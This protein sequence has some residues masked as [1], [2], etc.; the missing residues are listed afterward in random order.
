M[1][2]LHGSIQ[3]KGTDRWRVFATIRDDEGHPHKLTATV[4]GT[5]ADAELELERLL[6]TDGMKRDR[7]FSELAELYLADAERRVSNGTLAESTLAGYRSKLTKSILPALGRVMVSDITPARVTRFIASLNKDAPGTFRVLRTVLNWAYRNGYMRDRVCDR[8]EPVRQRTGAVTI[9]DVYTSDEVAVILNHPMD[10]ELKTAV[11]IALSCGL[12]RGE[13]CALEW[14]DYD[15]ETIHVRRSWGKDA[16]KTPNS[17]ARL[18]VPKWARDWLD[19]LRDDGLIIGL[20]PNQV[21]EAWRRLWF[22]WSH[23]ARDEA[24][25]V[26]YIP[27]KNLRHTS[28]SMVYEATHD[29]KATSR[30]GR[31]ASTYITERFY[32]RASDAVDRRCAD[33]LDETMGEGF[34]VSR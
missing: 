27:F 7:R 10:V 29:I 16:P 21:T 5:R 28:L 13:I 26:R 1:R 6:G 12:R 8:V 3:K 15:G 9:E 23:D 30:R 11:V 17:V 19:P 14:T 22:T 31:H 18:I 25:P 4:S 34:A 32:V 2:R 33:A 20:E 24:P